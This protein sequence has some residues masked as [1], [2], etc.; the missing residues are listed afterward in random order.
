MVTDD[1]LRQI[2]P[3]LPD[4]KRATFL[5]PLQS[6]MDEFAINTPMRQAAFLA[7]IAHE[8]AELT[9]F[10]ENLNYG[11]SGLLATWPKRFPDLQKAQQYERNPE[12]IANNVYANR[13]G[14][15]DEAS[16]DGWR[17]R[18]RGPIQITGREN[19]AKYGSRLNI[20]LVNNPDQ[21]ATPAV[22]FR[23][24]GFYWRENGLNESADAEMIETITRRIN[25][26]TKGLE[27]RVK[28]YELAKA[29]LGV[30]ASRGVLEPESMRGVTLPPEFTRGR[31]A[32]ESDEPAP[33][34]GTTPSQ[35]RKGVTRAPAKKRAVKKAAATK[36]RTAK[37][38]KAAKRKSRAPKR[39][40]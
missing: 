25:G 14:N 12:K 18:G 26:G 20:D 24:A 38:K 39:R 13:I 15:G 34:K 21:A 11:A 6:A 29:A 9:I 28:Y 23:I 10:V 40:K 36:S 31:E 2:M 32:L 33:K 17:F 5:S 16:G 1:S 3:R 22:G 19:Y 7:Q 35:K 8:S 37:T 27:E 30:P 4:A